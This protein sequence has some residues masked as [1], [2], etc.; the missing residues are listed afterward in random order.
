MIIK[1]NIDPTHD[2]VLALLIFS[3]TEKFFGTVFD[4]IGSGVR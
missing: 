1:K 4:E 2:R 3:T